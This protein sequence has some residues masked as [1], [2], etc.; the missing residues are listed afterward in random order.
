MVDH[1]QRTRAVLH[2]EPYDRLPIVHFGFWRET[3]D[4]WAAE[5]HITP[6]EAAT[7]ADG[8]ATDE[9]LSRKLGFDFNWAHTFGLNTS[10]LPPF[11]ERVLEEL[12]DGSRKVLNRNGVVIIQK[13]GASGIPPEVDH[14][15]KGRKEWEEHFLPRLQFTEERA[16]IPEET[17]A[18][19]QRGE[20]EK[21]LG[22]W[23]GSLYGVIRDWVGLVNLAYLQVD[24]PPLFDEMIETVG[25]LCYR[26]VE[27]VLQTG[28]P[29]DF[30]H[31]WEDICFKSGPLINP[32]VFRAK[33]APHYRRITELLRRHGITIVSVDCDGKID[34]LVPI[35]LESGVNTMFPIEVGTWNGNLAPWRQQY[36]RE[37][38][39]VGG[40]DKRVFARDYA[41]VD[42]EIERL[43]PLVELGGYI[44]CPDHRIPPDAK[45]E[46][47]QY[48]CERMRTIFG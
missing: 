34:R 19:L 39:G 17:I 41:A 14:L 45:W 24:D 12:P 29:F 46:N 7:W 23:C 4:K 27:R 26:C 42:A 37:L 31:F 15:L 3:L 5:G 9:A 20:W 25:N 1:R 28:A 33:V 8:N 35:W 38:R 22:L 10:L 13:E 48:Y 30:A 44:P 40:M 11:E 2:Y 36:G 16:F 21:P 6:D 47:V 18:Y 32:N 43:R